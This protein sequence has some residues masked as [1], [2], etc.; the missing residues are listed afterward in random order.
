MS[1]LVENNKLHDWTHSLV[2]GLTL[3]PGTLL[4]EMPPDAPNPLLKVHPRAPTLAS[5]FSIHH[6]LR[7]LINPGKN[8]LT[9]ENNEIFEKYSH[10]KGSNKWNKLY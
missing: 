1:R 9:G 10:N 4:W 6:L 2:Q 3:V 5:P 7:K 8:K